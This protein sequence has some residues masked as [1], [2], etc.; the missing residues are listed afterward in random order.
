M[1]TVAGRELPARQLVLPPPSVTDLSL[2]DHELGEY[3]YLFAL[4][5]YLVSSSEI[6]NVVIAQYRRMVINQDLGSV[7][8]KPNTKVVKPDLA[9]KLTLNRFI[10]VENGLMLGKPIEMQ[11]MIIGNYARNHYLEDLLSFTAT[12]IREKLL[13]QNQANNFLTNRFLIPC[14]SIGFMTTR[15]FV[16]QVH[17]LRCAVNVFVKASYKRREGYQRRTLGFLLERLH[18]YLLISAL[19]DSSVRERA[20]LGYRIVVTNDETIQGTR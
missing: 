18:S 14:P 9:D 10:P 6:T 3:Y 2:T 17:K 1:V 13:D 16:D 7:S 11:E 8:N 15:L 4:A 5:D 20:S 12:L 19:R